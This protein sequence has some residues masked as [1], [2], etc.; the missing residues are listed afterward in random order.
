MFLAWSH[1][2]TSVYIAI[3]FEKCL[4][5]NLI[6]I[7]SDPTHIRP[8]QQDNLSPAYLADFRNK[9]S[10]SLTTQQCI[11]GN[12][13]ISLRKGLKIIKLLQEIRDSYWIMS[14]LVG[15][16]IEYSSPLP[17]SSHSASK[18]LN[19]LFYLSLQD[20]HVKPRSRAQSMIDDDIDSDVGKTRIDADPSSLP[21]LKPNGAELKRTV[22]INSASNSTASSLN[23][24]KSRQNASLPFVSNSISNNLAKAANHV[25]NSNVSINYRHELLK[26]LDVIIENV[27]KSDIN[28]HIISNVGNNISPNDVQ[29]IVDYWS[30]FNLLQSELESNDKSREIQTD[31]METNDASVISSPSRRKRSIQTSSRNITVNGSFSFVPLSIDDGIS[32][33]DLF[34][35]NVNEFILVLIRCWEREYRMMLSFIEKSKI[36]IQRRPAMTGLNQSQA[37][38]PFS[39]AEKQALVKLLYFY[40]Q[41]HPRNQFVDIDWD[42]VESKYEH[43][44]Y[45]FKIPPSLFAKTRSQ[46]SKLT[47]EQ[48]KILKKQLVDDEIAA[49]GEF[50]TK[51]EQ[52]FD[53]T[54]L[55]EL[56]I[57]PMLEKRTFEDNMKHHN[58]HSKH[59]HHEHQKPQDDLVERLLDPAV[60]ANDEAKHQEELKLQWQQHKSRTTVLNKKSGKEPSRA[61]SQGNVAPMIPKTIS[62]L[63]ECLPAK[64]SHE[65]YEKLKDQYTVGGMPKSTL[66]KSVENETSR[67]RPLSGNPYNIRDITKPQSNTPSTG[68]VG[69][70]LNVQ[71]A[72][73]GEDAHH[74]N[75]S[76]AEMV[77]M[78]E[79]VNQHHPALHTSKILPEYAVIDGPKKSSILMNTAT[80]LLSV[81]K[82]VAA[83]TFPTVRPQSGSLL[84]KNHHT[85]VV[86]YDN[87]IEDNPYKQQLEEYFKS[88]IDVSRQRILN[89]TLQNISDD[90]SSINNDGSRIAVITDNERSGSS[91]NNVLSSP[92]RLTWRSR[93]VPFLNLAFYIS[94]TTGNL[95]LNLKNSF[96]AESAVYYMTLHCANCTVQALQLALQ[97]YCKPWQL[98]FLKILDLSYNP[99]LGYKGSCFLTQCLLQMKSPSQLIHLNL[100]SMHIGDHG[101]ALLL[102]SLIHCK[103]NRT[104]LRLD[105]KNNDITIAVKDSFNLLREFVHLRYNF[106]YL[107]SFMFV[108]SDFLSH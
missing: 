60:L 15:Y 86:D 22:T 80:Q 51:I 18:L 73:I 100:N 87:S 96:L 52:M 4:K 105:L 55:E 66:T 82:N 8:E 89:R 61:A 19:V 99:Q 42:E 7:D 16:C 50:N 79:V 76:A 23:S 13:T 9:L 92:S 36:K 35:L 25:S 54:V 95:T 59:I 2:A 104:L 11:S 106:V 28:T 43:K 31:E 56:P 93:V 74:K 32:I 81:E 83:L 64:E 107:S 69:I 63:N 71:V 58:S 94:P 68:G 49:L 10:K 62:E 46:L 30:S 84:R 34:T 20:D 98:D 29:P 33:G 57:L 3:Y 48:L 38:I 26:S 53:K 41:K 77:T 75:I 40:K 6:T 103:G 45:P 78:V 85:T 14:P 101:L 47:D 1:I 12:R 44:A 90:Q 5:H 24:H 27:W 108:Y 67:V 21:T 65:Q 97:T 88:K 17:W 91:S 102:S 39:A 72:N 70:G 37:Q